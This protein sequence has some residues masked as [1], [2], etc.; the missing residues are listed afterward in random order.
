MLVEHHV[1]GLLSDLKETTLDLNHTTKTRW[2]HSPRRSYKEGSVKK[3][4]EDKQHEY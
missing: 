1:K 3:G 2:S 4:G